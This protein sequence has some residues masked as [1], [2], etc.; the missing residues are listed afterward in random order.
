MRAA[1][2]YP[3]I[4]LTGG[5]ERMILEL[6]RHSR[7][8]WTLLTNH[9]EPD[10]TF[11]GF[12]DLGVVTLSEV[13]VERTIPHVLRAAATIRRERVD[14]TGLDAALIA[15]EGLGNLKA[16]RLGVP[17]SCLCMT[18]L[19]VAYEPVTRERLLGGGGLAYRAA[20][21]GYRA[22]DRR[23][24][25]R[26]ERVFAISQEVRRRLLEAGLVDEARLEVIH[27]GVDTTRFRPSD[28]VDP[29]FLVP[30]RIMWQKN[31][32][33]AIEAWRRSGVGG[34]RTRLVVAGMVDRKSVPYFEHLRRLAAGSDVEFR[35]GPSDEE[36][37]DLYQR[38][39]AVIFPAP[40]EDFGLVPLEAMA[41]GKPVVA[42]D[43]GGPKETVV[44]DITGFLRLPTAEAF[45][46]A[47]TKLA[48]MPAGRYDA[49]SRA[50]RERALAFG[51]DRF[52]A[53]IDDHVE[54]LTAL[55]GHRGALVR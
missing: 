52:A 22:I 38:C 12:R 6:V 45:A 36:L 30:G 11:P 1:L 32:E 54:E 9:Y 51:W 34:R 18:P 2:Y 24:W 16:D 47:I 23:T 20:F 3:W 8:D 40:N 41:C 31:V 44:D 53:R 14:L 42:T 46:D 33:L 37:L 17:T 10:A 43:R 25:R 21:A 39:H 5:A 29:F 4:Y 15:S 48:T 35:I 27:P 28:A 7:I 26:Y 13:S 50:A 55:R 49:L 19:K